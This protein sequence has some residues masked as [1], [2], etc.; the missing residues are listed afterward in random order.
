[1]QS[2][3]EAVFQHTESLPLHYGKGFHQVPPLPTLHHYLLH[4]PVISRRRNANIP[5][6]LAWKHDARVHLVL[7]NSIARMST[8]VDQQSQRTGKPEHHIFTLRSLRKR[9]SN[10]IACKLLTLSFDQGFLGRMTVVFLF[11]VPQYAGRW[12]SQ[13]CRSFILPNFP[14][15]GTASVLQLSTTTTSLLKQ[16]TPFR[17]HRTLPCCSGYHLLQSFSSA[18]VST[19]NLIRTLTIGLQEQEFHRSYCPLNSTMNNCSLP[20]FQGVQL[21]SIKDR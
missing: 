3:L 7:H 11:H 8:P 10:Y 12:F 9:E 5:L 2:F 16:E 14:L 4:S 21:T 17:T 1:M 13:N 19:Q 20:Q 18:M 15:S 6:L